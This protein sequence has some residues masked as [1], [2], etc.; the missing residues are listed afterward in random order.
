MNQRKSTDAKEEGA[1]KPHSI[2]NESKPVTLK[3]VAQRAHTSVST[4]SLVMNNKKVSRISPEVREKVLES[5]RALGYR[6]NAMAQNLVRGYSQ[7]IGLVTDSIATAPFAGQ[8]IHGAQ[9]AA[10]EQGYVLLIAN[11]E[12]N[13]GLEDE[14]IR[15]F[16]RYKVRGI[17]FSTW[18][19]HSIEVPK[20]LENVRTV[21]VNCFGNKKNSPLAIVPDEIQGGRTATQLLLERGHSKIAFVN[22]RAE[23]PAKTG[24]L[25]GYKQAL[26]ESGITFDPSLTFEVEPNQEGGRSVARRVKDSGAT[27]VFCHNDRVAMGLYD[28]LQRGGSR[29]PDDISIVGFDDQEI[30]A[31]HLSPPLTTVALPHYQLGYEG[32]KA[33]LN[34]DAPMTGKQLVVCPPVIRASVATNWQ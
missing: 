21:L 27:G 24:R 5:I 10:W 4:V 1:S 34:E 7:F 19:H 15:M 9:N 17:A 18:Y 29:I 32:V 2:K 13:R 33:I 14:A 8:I 12:G 25:D 6:P 31:A 16:L 3:D 23:S 28:E 30:I 11:T 22:T 26:R 20:P